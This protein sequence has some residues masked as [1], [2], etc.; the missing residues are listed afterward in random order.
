MQKK[1]ISKN[2]SSFMSYQVKAIATNKVERL[3]PDKLSFP[4]PQNLTIKK[5]LISHF[6]T[7][8]LKHQNK[9][10]EG[11]KQFIKSTILYVHWFAL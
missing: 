10:H 7:V 1:Q 6:L 9:Q 3:L 11:T 5:Q 2:N 4:H 8:A